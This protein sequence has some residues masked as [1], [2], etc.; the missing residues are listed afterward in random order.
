[1]AGESAV[2]E[3]AI[4]AGK[5]VIRL[6]PNWVPRAFCIPGKRLK[7]HQDDYYAFGAHRGGIDERWFASTVK[8]D[9][10]PETLEDEGL[11]YIYF[12]DGEVEHKIL[13]RDAIEL[14]GE[15][16]LGKAVMEKYGGWLM[17]AKFFDNM[18]PLP[19]HLHQ[20][21][22]KAA[23]VGQKG[24]PEGYYFPKQ[25]NNHP[26]WFPYTF[27]GLNPGTTRDDVIE[28][29]KNWDNGDNGILYHSSAYK[30]KLGT[31]WNVPPGIL[32]APGSL[33]TYE[34]QRSSDV[35]AMFQNIVWDQFMPWDFLV[36]DVPEEH[37]KDLDFIVDLIDWEANL[38][39]EFYKNRFLEPKPVKSVEEM[40]DEGYEENWIVYGSEYFSAKELTVFPEREVVIKDSGPYGLIVIEGHGKFQ[41]LEIGAPD[42]I[43]FGQMTKDELFVTYE[44]AING[45]VIKNESDSQNLVILKHFGPE[46]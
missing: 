42:V 22:E 30:L 21:D 29:L 24:K 41:G 28:C 8:A 12:K 33:L 6:F 2:I 9:N 26:G 10:G 5:G 31:G 34:P 23:L 40:R 43:R 36:K 32:H 7:L 20:D 13:L 45:V 35:F 44:A 39:P 14:S 19:H 17:F 15:K 37:K 46:V 27:F 4:D 11:S 18:E 38:D 3:R 1:M 16:I 25:L